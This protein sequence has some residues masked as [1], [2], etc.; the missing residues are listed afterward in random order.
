MTPDRLMPWL[1]R[2]DDTWPDQF[3]RLQAMVD[4]ALSGGEAD[5]RIGDLVRQVAGIEPHAREQMRLGRLARKL[6][7]LPSQ[8]LPLRPVRIGLAGSA[9]VSFLA[10][11]LP[12]AGLARGL[13]IDAAEAP[14]GSLQ[15][16][17]H[18][19]GGAFFPD[20]LDALVVLADEAAVGAP[21]SLTDQDGA[22]A[23]VRAF[24]TL[25]GAL[26]DTVA[27]AH[28]AALVVATQP[29][30]AGSVSSADWTLP[31]SRLRL[32]RRLN[33][34]IA[35]GA[36]ARRWL[37]WDMA[38]L[39]GRVG[40]NRW[41][42]PVGYH[43]AK[44]P[45]RVD[46][47]HL[48]ADHLSAVLAAKFGVAPRGLVLD[49]DN[50]LWGGVIGDDGV[51]GI[52][53]GSGSSEGEAYAQFQKFLLGLRERGLVLT[54]SSK[55]DDAVAREPFRTHPDMVLKEEH[56]AV[57]QANW[58][59]KAT[60]IATIAS[61]LTLG[62]GSFVFVDDNP[63]ERARVRQE[64]PAVHVPEIGDDPADYTPR[65]VAS[66]LFEHLPLTDEDLKRADAYGAQA[67]R[68]ELSEKLGNYDSYLESLD[69]T[70]AV[71]AFD[72][73]GLPRIAQLINKS[74][75]FN[76]TTRRYSEAD[77]RKMADDG[78]LTFQARLSDR[79]SD[80]GMIAVI[81]A[82]LQESTD[83][84]GADLRIDTW[85]QSCR[86]LER[87]VEAALM[88][89]VMDEAARLGVRTVI[90]EYIR[91]ARNGMVADF[92]PKLGFE[93]LEETDTGATFVAE[94]GTWLRQ[95]HKIAL[96]GQNPAG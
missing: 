81:I 91:T 84:E 13:C 3:T 70:L 63:A 18:G 65:L 44:A 57:L 7:Q 43:H 15:P 79:F 9:N 8:A 71:S 10:G 17:A 89:L 53:I 49:L 96:A 76:L 36:A 83:G 35:E 80:H 12:G 86:V 58:N 67:Q 75:Q 42:D 88:N 82:R 16:L 85:L 72:D 60:N 77:V 32:R 55:N 27:Q 52:R 48:V 5:A 23:A 64:L 6:R 41:L 90:G 19:G 34:V 4:E 69:M 73:V 38:E 14:Y 20:G 11:A 59:D 22:D 78:T 33:E 68:L 31:G 37:L 56:F 40:L 25:L 29:E 54:A 47:S 51:A 26:A 1:P 21:V 93:R 95:E 87:G 28:G 94:P 50:T 2:P 62:T 66:R 46:L 45:F 39:A 74:N 92:Y 24:E 61:N 30:A